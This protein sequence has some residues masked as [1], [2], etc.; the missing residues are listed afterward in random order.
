[1]PA[2]RHP[3]RRNSTTAFVGTV[4]RETVVTLG[5]SANV[6]ADV[7]SVNKQLVI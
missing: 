1:M 3:N 7:C 6:L 5:I 2:V 4:Y